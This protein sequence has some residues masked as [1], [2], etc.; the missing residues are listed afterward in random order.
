M[1]VYG[2]DPGRDYEIS[3]DV[4]GSE[5]GGEEQHHQATV[6]I[7]TGVESESRC[8]LRYAT[9]NAD[10][11]LP[12]S[13]GT[14]Q[15]EDAD[16]TTP[17]ADFSAP[18][19]SSH[20]GPSSTPEGPPPPYSAS[21]P[22]SPPNESQLRALLKKI[23]ASSKR[24][25]SVLN[26]SIQALKKSVEKGMKEDQRARTRI[27]SLEEAIRKAGE[28]ERESR[29]KEMDACEERIR[30]LEELE[31]E[32]KEELE[33]RKEGKAPT[34]APKV[35]PDPTPVA[36]PEASTAAEEGGEEED[37][38]EGIADLARE[39]DSLNKLIDEAEKETRRKA[40]DSLRSLEMEL[41]QIDH[42]IL[43]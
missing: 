38:H 21:L 3:L 30:E 35:E 4:V 26:A 7:E 34:P 5:E 32:V 37:T 43:A 1:I 10:C 6:E 33:R 8:T 19:P 41:S 28:G 17:E 14:R 2:L 12:S 27:V 22:P 11:C 18:S 25:E 42:E 23:R 16:S 36:G 13:T 9:K 40:K 39:L 24:T 29:T 31:E 15:S 20:A